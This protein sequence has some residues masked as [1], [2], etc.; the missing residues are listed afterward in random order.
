MSCLVVHTYSRTYIHC[1]SIHIGFKCLVVLKYSGWMDLHAQSHT[2][3]SGLTPPFVLGCRAWWISIN[4]H[5]ADL[6]MTIFREVST[7]RVTWAHEQAACLGPFI[8]TC[9]DAARIISPKLTGLR[10]QGYK[11][12]KFSYFEKIKTG[13]V[14]SLFDHLAPDKYT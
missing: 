6:T 12:L 1:C 4:P 8:F 10:S 11:P 3:T 7:C 14:P 9:V 2:H 13:T 5:I